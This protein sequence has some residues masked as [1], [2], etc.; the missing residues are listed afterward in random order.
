M[1]SSSTT[2]IFLVGIKHSGKS[3]AGRILAERLAARF[4]DQDEL[5]LSNHSSGFVVTGIRDLY[6]HVGSE[7]FAELELESSVELARQPGPIVV[8]C[9]GGI[10]DNAQA[11]SVVASA[12]VLMMIEVEA[13][14]AWERVIAGGIPAF[15]GTDR[16]EV[17]GERFAEL[18]ERRM[19]R[20]REVAHACVPAA[21]TP[22]QTA[23]ALLAA[24]EELN[25]GR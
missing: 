25:R 10:A 12:G 6:Q 24:F 19:R 8:A 22:E 17:A 15:L 23:S 21:A 13:D 16:A 4:V 1:T 5:I 3:S 14:T 2:R 9:G 11:I 18:A 7:R 20:Y